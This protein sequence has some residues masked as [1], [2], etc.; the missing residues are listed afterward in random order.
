VFLAGTSGTAG[1]RK[2]ERVDHW[3]ELRNGDGAIF[4]SMACKACVHPSRDQIDRRLIDGTPLRDIAA[5][6]GLS[7]GGLSRHRTH[8]RQTL[9]L[10]LKERGD[11]ERAEN[12]S[13][14]LQRVQK[15]VGEAEEILATAKSNGNL[16]AATSAIC[17]AVRVLELVG[18]LDGSLAQ[19]NTPGLHLTLNK[20]TINV[21]NYDDDIDFAQMIGEATRGFDVTELLR[22]KAIAENNNSVQ[23]VCN[24][25]STV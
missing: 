10:A 6:T 23:P 16:R 13:D 14:L 7:L 11:D 9:G 18:R 21:T 19:P 1:P 22:L 8:L 2:T 5:S 20:T 12:G 24:R 3:V 25:P 15:L 17:A 4:Q